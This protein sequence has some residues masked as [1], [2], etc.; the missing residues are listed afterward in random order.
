MTVTYRIVNP[1]TSSADL[2]RAQWVAMLMPACEA[3]AEKIGISPEAI[4]A[5]AALETGWGRSA[6]GNNIFGIKATPGWKGARKIVGTQEVIGGQ[7]I[8]INDEFRDYPSLEASVADHF[9]FLDENSR[10]R[11][12]GVFDAASDEAYFV[13]LQRAGYATDPSYAHSLMSV[14]RTV[15][16]YTAGMIREDSTATPAGTTSKTVVAG[17]VTVAAGA[18]SIAEQISDIAPTLD[19]VATVG[20]SLA[21]I[22]KL[23][24]VALSIIALA[25]GAYMLWRYLQKRKRGEVVST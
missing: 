21:N 8:S 1:P 9:R 18:A 6:I 20:P 13:A 7:R 2:K 25:A 11:K 22:L 12:A 10:Y 17:G 4:V 5:Q 14:L 19:A 24:A 23:G 15:Q 16:R 3:T